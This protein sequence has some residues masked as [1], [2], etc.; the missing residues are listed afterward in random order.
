M[1]IIIIYG[2]PDD[3]RQEENL[4]SK[5]MRVIVEI[6][7]LKLSPASI[8]MFLPRD[9]LRPIEGLGEEIIILVEG[10]FKRTERT[11]EVRNKLAYKLVM[12]VSDFFPW[13][14]VKCLVKSFDPELGYAD[15]LPKEV[16]GIVDQA[17]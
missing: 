6:E 10:L 15:F 16:I 5:L 13:S 3:F 8:S 14:K 17:G 9:R 1:P 12:A 11:A 4:K 7:E 2:L